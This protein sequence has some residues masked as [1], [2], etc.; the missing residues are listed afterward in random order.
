MPV[1][2]LDEL[3]RNF[4]RRVVSS[5]L[6]LNLGDTLRLSGTRDQSELAA[7]DYIELVPIIPTVPL[8]F[9]VE[10]EEMSL[11]NYTALSDAPYASSS[12]LVSIRTPSGTSGSAR[13]PFPK[14]SGHYDVVVG[15]YDETD[16]EAHFALQG[17]QP[18][19]SP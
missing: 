3:A 6:T 18:H 10:A 2:P 4:V 5:G 7:I 17:V 11:E 16:G 14:A 12:G 1:L 19:P 9:R 8:P 13:F 15:Y